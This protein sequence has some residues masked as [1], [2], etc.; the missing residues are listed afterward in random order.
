MAKLTTE[1]VNSSIIP[2]DSTRKDLQEA[3]NT[4]SNKR[5][6]LDN[7]FNYMDGPQP[8]KYSTTKLQEL[9][10]DI[11]AHFEMNWCSVVVD[12]TLDRI[13]LEGFRVTNDEAAT[14]KLQ[15]VFDKLHLD[16]E[17][18]DAHKASLATSQAYIIVWKEEG[19]TAIYYNDPRLCHVFYEDSSPKKKRFAA[20]WFNRSGGGQEITLYY[21][22]RI[23][24][25]T[26]QKQ[27]VQKASAF[28][29]ESSEGNTFGVIP[30]FDLKSEGEIFKV[31]T[32]QD[33]VN[34]LFDDMMVAGEFSAVLQKYV[35]SQS[36]PGMLKNAANAVWWIPA[37]D[38]QGQQGSAGYF[39]PTELSNFS[40]EIDKLAN[41]IAIITRTPKHYFLNTGANISGEAL[42]AMESPLVKKAGK[43][44]KKF[45]AQWQDI[46]AFI[47]QL[48]GVKVTADQIKPMWK[49]AESIQP[50]TEMQTVQAGTNAGVD[51]ETMLRH[52]GWD[53]KEIDAM[54]KRKQANLK[55]RVNSVRVP[56]D[57]NNPDGQNNPQD[58]QQ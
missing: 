49:R 48:E 12:A 19:E 25:W 58:V 44:Q 43:R 24:H 3:F 41:A 16:L 30:V 32:I 23:E 38:G 8:L 56:V 10:N 4:I 14:Q 1:E 46:A 33:A 42:L 15:A 53:D 55:K 17:A 9:F 31:L 47:A 28:V 39:P 57:T 2:A 34:K 40:N 13:Q 36:D 26:S 11:N 37:G 6:G 52:E 21:T 22:D 50:L 54:N 51:I 27:K 20:K 18:D 5:A 45:G 7:L 29:L 35:I